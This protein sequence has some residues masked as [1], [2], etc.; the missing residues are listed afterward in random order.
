MLSAL[1]FLTFLFLIAA[2]WFYGGKARAN[3][4]NG[5]SLTRTTLGNRKGARGLLWVDFGKRDDFTEAGWRYRNLT[6]L[7]SILALIA[8]LSW[9]VSQSV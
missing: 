7:C 9:G 4:A 3:L 6:I 8:L 1:I 5:V 2:A